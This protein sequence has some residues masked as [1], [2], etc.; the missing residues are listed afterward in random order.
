M[1]AWFRYHNG[2]AGLSIQTARAKL[3]ARGVHRLPGQSVQDVAFTFSPD[4]TMRTWTQVGAKGG[5]LYTNSTVYSSTLKGYVRPYANPA[6]CARPAWLGNRTIVY[7]RFHMDI[8][9]NGGGAAGLQITR[10]T[11]GKGMMRFT[12][13]ATTRTTKYI[14]GLM[15]SGDQKHVV[16]TD[17]QGGAGVVDLPTGASRPI[18]GIGSFRKPPFVA[19]IRGLSRDGRVAAVRLSSNGDTPG[20]GS[21]QPFA[22]PPTLIDTKTG[23]KEPIPVKGRLI[24]ATYLTGGGLL[25][26]V[27]GKPANTLV[28]LVGGTEV[29]RW[30]EPAAMRT[31]GLVAAGG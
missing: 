25:V 8:R 26:R 12:R 1:A 30:T 16:G 18:P 24:D 21:R 27:A 3:G 17:G 19:D 2:S 31:W 13:V 22:S 14:C 6:P 23:A 5:L 7:P 15:A 11:T 29:K 4:T 28:L 20:D 9:G 10:L